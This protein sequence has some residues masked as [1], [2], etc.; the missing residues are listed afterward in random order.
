MAQGYCRDLGYFFGRLDSPDEL[1]IAFLGHND[2]TV[3]G[4]ARILSDIGPEN[5]HVKCS[6]LPTGSVEITVFDCRDP[7]NFSDTR[8]RPIEHVSRFISDFESDRKFVITVGDLNF[9]LYYD[10]LRLELDHIDWV[11]EYQN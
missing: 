8:K 5:L 9:N 3:Y 2:D 10:I 6:L 7:D 1:T 11:T 4:L